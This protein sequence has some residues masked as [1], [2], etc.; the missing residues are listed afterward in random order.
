MSIRT[1]LRKRPA[2]YKGEVGL[3]PDNEMA[4]EDLRLVSLYEE[5]Q[6]TVATSSKIELEKYRWA[7]ATKVAEARDD[8]LDKEDA[9]DWLKIRVRFVKYVENPRTKRMEVLPKSTRRLSPEQLRRLINRMQH[10][11]LTE[12]MPG[13]RPSVLRDELLKMCGATRR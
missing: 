5:A 11:V 10:V 12:V 13:V 3:F 1:I 8:L 4:G 2:L 6:C 7:L 9:M